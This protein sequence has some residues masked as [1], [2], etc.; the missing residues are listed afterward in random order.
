M[1]RRRLEGAL[2]RN[3][4][5]SD[6]SGLNIVAEALPNDGATAAAR[7]AKAHAIS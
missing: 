6:C 4:G 2:C 3:S 5:R 1:L 7:S